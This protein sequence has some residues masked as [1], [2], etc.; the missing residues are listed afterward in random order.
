VLLVPA[1]FKTPARCP[2]RSMLSQWS[3]RLGICALLALSLYSAW[4]ALAQPEAQTS[5]SAP[6]PSLVRLSEVLST[7]AFVGKDLDLIWENRHRLR[8]SLSAFARDTPELA[9]DAE[10]LVKVSQLLAYV[11]YYVLPRPKRTERMQAFGLGFQIA[12]RAIEL[13]NKHPGA[14]HWFAVNRMAYADLAGW[15]EPLLCAAEVL[16]ALQTVVNL[17]PEFGSGAGRRARGLLYLKMPPSPVSMGD[18]SQALSD[19]RAA[20]ALAPDDKHSLMALAIAESEAGNQQ[21]ALGL[22]ARARGSN[23]S[24]GLLEDQVIENELSDLERNLK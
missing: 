9:D 3:I 17:D 16:E 18:L 12:E 7:G 6:N 14:H 1:G 5:Q 11:G 22:I 13:N 15:I 4:P 24:A 2:S 23:N 20:H 19:L 21:E 10:E 8:G